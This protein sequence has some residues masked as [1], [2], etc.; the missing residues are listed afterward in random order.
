MSKEKFDFTKAYEEIEEINEWFQKEEI[1]LE[2]ALNKYEKGMEL[3]EKCKK[4]LEKSKNK[5]EEI[6][7]KYSEE[8]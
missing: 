2:E 7:E 8:E 5:F 1:D 4:R 6:K 3:I